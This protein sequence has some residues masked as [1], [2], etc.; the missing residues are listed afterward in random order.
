MSNDT[1]NQNLPAYEDMIKAGM[2]FGRKKTIF[3]PNMKPFIYTAREN[4]Y[5][6][7]LIKT[8]D[9]LSKAIDFLQTTI[10]D[11]KTI[12]FVGTT[13]QSSDLVK[14]AAEALSMPYVTY[15]WLGGTL[16]NFKVII[17][18]VKHLEELER[19]QREGEFEKFTKKEKLLKEREIENLKRKYDGLRKL[20]KMPDVV[21]VSSL[22]E[23]DLPVKE[24]RVK[25]IKTVGIVNTDSDPKRLNYPIPAN[26]TSRQSVELILE[27][28]KLNLSNVVPKTSQTNE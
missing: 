27:A 21:F 26:D 14:S 20:T 18:R 1:N 23:N 5:I 4:I 25:K 3:H 28:I 2:H 17:A 13:K 15:R 11:S 7:D 6:L 8:A 22:K 24:A 12:L 19:Q 10:E 9:L 16:T